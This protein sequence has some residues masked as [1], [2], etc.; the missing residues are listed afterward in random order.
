MNFSTGGGHNRPEMLVIQYPPGS[1]ELKVVYPHDVPST[2]VGDIQFPMPPWGK[3]RCGNLGSGVMYGE[4]ALDHLRPSSECSGHGT[5]VFN[6]RD[7]TQHEVYKCECD[8]LTSWSGENCELMMVHVISFEPVLAVV[9]WVGGLVVALC[10]AC[11]VARCHQHRKIRRKSYGTFISHHQVSPV[12]RAHLLTLVW[13]HE[14]PQSY[15]PG[16][17]GGGCAGAVGDVRSA[18][19]MPAAS[20]VRPPAALLGRERGCK[21]RVCQAARP[22]DPGRVQMFVDLLTAL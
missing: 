5:C 21:G 10:V 11:W 20:G 8:R 16:R 15:T 12:A 13:H 7:T 17:W 18:S 22:P 2:S 4:P 9:I 14:S 1:K 19:S 6:Y 3:R